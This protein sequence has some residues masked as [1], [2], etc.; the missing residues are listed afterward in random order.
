MTFVD[1]K[2]KGLNVLFKIIKAKKKKDKNKKAAR[3]TKH[4]EKNLLCVDSVNIFIHCLQ[5]FT[6]NSIT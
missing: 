6:K 4:P 2:N 5:E 3:P 1:I